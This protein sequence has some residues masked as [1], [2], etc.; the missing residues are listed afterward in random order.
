MKDDKR[1]VAERLARPGLLN[2]KPYS[3]A[4]DEFQGEGSVWLDA[5]ESPFGLRYKGIPGLNR[6]PDPLQSQLKEELSKRYR[7]PVH[8]IFAGNGSD[9]IIDLMIRA[10]CTPGRDTVIIMPPT[11]GM[12]EVQAR[13]H[14]L[15]VAE[16]PLT[17]QFLPDEEAIGEAAAAAVAAG[18]PAKILFICSPNNPT[19]NI[20]PNETIASIAAT[21]DGIVMVDEAYIDFSGSD[22]ALSLTERYDNIMVIRTF[23]KARGMAGARLGIGFSNREITDLLNRIKLPYN[24]NSLTIDAGLRALETEEA[25]LQQIELIVEERE[26]ISGELGKISGISK[27]WPSAANFLL[28]SV[29]EPLKLYRHL[30][31][32]GIVI[33]DR[34]KVRG[35]EGTLRITVGTPPQNDLLLEAIADYFSPSGSAQPAFSAGTT[36]TVQRR[37]AETDIYVRFTPLGRGIGDIETGVGFLDHMLELL[38][39]HSG[40]NIM[41]RGNG[42]LH[43][44]AHHLVEDVALTLGA[45][46][47]QAVKNKPLERYGFTLPMDESLAT[48]AVD[49]SGRP[50]L[51][52]DVAFRDAMIGDMPAEMVEHFFLS[53]ATAARCTINIA[54]SGQNDHHIAEAVFKAFG[55]ALK[56]ALQPSG[57]DRVA[58][59]KGVI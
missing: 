57:G 36:E 22:G 48:V 1:S 41:I 27:V 49:I 43:I 12:Y 37:T 33:R 51:V 35:C 52:F 28:V 14:D 56:M 23:S 5:N 50:V 29:E 25:T 42:D 54:A 24:V 30:L 55:R 58:S 44:D 40:S 7:V 11:Y 15:N 26:R 31:E 16:V 47:G 19:G 32:R 45:A 17:E 9:E 8:S 2:L 4:R 46:I 39:F 18:R 38:A 21:F 10:F 34:S 20:T 53:L 13:I 3:S 6:Y 59:S